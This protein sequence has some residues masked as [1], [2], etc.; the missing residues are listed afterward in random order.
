LRATCFIHVPSD[1]RFLNSSLTLSVVEDH[2]AV[3]GERRA[4]DVFAQS[5]SALLVVGGDLGCCVKIEAMVLGA[6]FAFGNGA[7][8]GVEH[9]ADSLGI[10]KGVK[11]V[12]VDGKKVAGNVIPHEAS[13]TIVKVEITLEA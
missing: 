4:Q 5:Q 10:C 12:V 8:V 6:E 2:E 13:K 7:V 1:H 3:V 11:S 9:D